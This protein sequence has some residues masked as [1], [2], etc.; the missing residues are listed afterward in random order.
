MASTNFEDLIMRDTR[1]N[2]PAAGVPGRLYYV[3]DENVTERDNGATWDDITDAG[4]GGGAS[5]ADPFIIGK[6]TAADLSAAIQ[7]PGLSSHPDKKAAGGDDDEFDALSGWTTLGSLDT[8]NV[9]D[10]ASLY[11]IKK[12]SSGT[13]VDGIY[14]AKSGAFTMTAKMNDYLFKQNYQTPGIMIGEA[15]PGKLVT[16]GPQYSL[17][18][19]ELNPWTNRTT[20]GT[21]QDFSYAPFGSNNAGTLYLQIVAHSDSDV[22]FNVSL[23]GYFFNMLKSAYNPG[24]TIGSVGICVIGF[25]AVP[26]EALFD[27]VRF[28]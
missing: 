25:A 12:N 21:Q 4:A 20:R 10:Y 26:C 7:I 24:F 14:K 17:N 18:G 8:S 15:S 22:D 1:A 16:W 5:T 23:T 2:Q 19:L 28:T 3:T 13:Q 27:W 11:H 9:T 6:G